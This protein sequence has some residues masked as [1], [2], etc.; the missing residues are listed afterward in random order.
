MY[1]APIEFF[2]NMHPQTPPSLEDP[3]AELLTTY[4]ELNTLAIDELHE[5]PSALEF[6]RYVARNR[7]FVIRGG[8]SHWEA[9]KT[10][11]VET[12]KELL[13]GQ[14]V[15]VAVTPFG[16]ILERGEGRGDG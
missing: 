9:T 5:L 10:W 7:P 3:I 2:I 4:D 11:N 1:K 13:A 14:S 8:A 15:N 12:L 16:Y 6:M